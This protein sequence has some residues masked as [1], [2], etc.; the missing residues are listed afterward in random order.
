M[1]CGLSQCS[2]TWTLAWLREIVNVSSY[3]SSIEVECYFVIQIIEEPK[4]SSWC[5]FGHVAK[6]IMKIFLYLIAWRSLDFIW[7]KHLEPYHHA[8]PVEGIMAELKWSLYLKFLAKLGV[9]FS[10][11]G[12]HRIQ[13]IEVKNPNPVSHTCMHNTVY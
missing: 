5:L 7:N 4:N 2:H 12:K 6:M 1:F 9:S 3:L 11:Q 13:T 8:R 10:W